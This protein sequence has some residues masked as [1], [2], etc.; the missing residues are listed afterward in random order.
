MQR[1]LQFH[2]HAFPNRL[3]LPPQL[4][5]SL[6]VEDRLDLAVSAAAVAAPAALLWEAPGA[7]LRRQGTAVKLT[8]WLTPPGEVDPRSM[9]GATQF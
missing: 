6:G 8:A 5:A 9:V 2:L 7:A 3:R 4:L 1:D